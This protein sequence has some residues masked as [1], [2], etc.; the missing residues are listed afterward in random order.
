MQIA[1]KFVCGVVQHRRKERTFVVVTYVATE[2]SQDAQVSETSSTGRRG[3]THPYRYFAEYA[4]LTV[5]LVQV[6]NAFQ[7]HESHLSPWF[8]TCAQSVGTARFITPVS[9]VNVTQ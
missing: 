4:E 8:V 2:A 7:K 3:S 1:A 5:N 9:A 6:P